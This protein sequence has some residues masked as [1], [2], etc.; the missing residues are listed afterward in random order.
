MQRRTF[1]STLP[2]SST[3]AVLGK[4]ALP[5]QPAA[6]IQQVFTGKVIWGEDLMQLTLAGPVIANIEGY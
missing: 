6:E 2:A 3:A 5:A 1:V 4:E